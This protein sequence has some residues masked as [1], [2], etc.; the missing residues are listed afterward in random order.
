MAQKRTIAPLPRG[1]N[2]A[3]K[4]WLSEDAERNLIATSAQGAKSPL[5]TRLPFASAELLQDAVMRDRCSDH[6]A[7]YP[8][9]IVKLNVSPTE[10]YIEITSGNMAGRTQRY[11]SRN[12][13]AVKSLR[14]SEKA[15]HGHLAHVSRTS[16]NG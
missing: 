10:Y 3:R 2:R 6:Q 4:W 14:F 12:H 16:A 8:V 1:R 13:S 5:H 7:K 15:W 11:H 9:V